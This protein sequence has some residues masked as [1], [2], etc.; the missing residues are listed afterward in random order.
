MP[1][2]TLLGRIGSF[3]QNRRPWYKLPDLLAM[4]RLVE[5]RNELRAKN[6]HDT[7]EPAL[8]KKPIPADLDPPT[9]WSR[10]RAS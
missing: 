2:E 7:E 9:C 10:I 3:L 1:D 4:P 5:I 6:L 8:E